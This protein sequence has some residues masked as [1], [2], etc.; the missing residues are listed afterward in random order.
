M[1]ARAPWD[2]KKKKKKKKNGK[3]MS[4]LDAPLIPGCFSF[5]NIFG[6]LLVFADYIFF[7]DDAGSNLGR[8]YEKIFR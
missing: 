1:S 2:L 8:G 3:S 5:Y 7:K 4:F 6:S